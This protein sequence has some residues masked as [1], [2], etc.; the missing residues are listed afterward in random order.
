MYNP[1]QQ[2]NP[3]TKIDQKKKGYQSNGQIGFQLKKRLG[4]NEE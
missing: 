2:K 1:Q 4:V 3:T